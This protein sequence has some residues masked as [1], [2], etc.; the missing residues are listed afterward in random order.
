MITRR[1]IIIAA[2]VVAAIATPFVALAAQQLLPACA[3]DYGRC[4]IN[5]IVQTFVNF[6]RLLL[7][8]VGS[9]VL[10]FFIYGGFVWL[11]SGGSSE[12]IKK[13]KDVVVNS[14][15]GLIIVFGAFTIVQFISDSLGVENF[16]RVGQPCINGEQAG[17][18]VADPASPRS[19]L[20]CITSCAE[21]PLPAA[22]YSCRD[23]AD[24]TNCI[25]GL[26]PGSANNQ[27]CQA[28]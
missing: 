14:I 24:G 12:K 10:V 27:C 19:P 6:M 13:G 1:N 20:L 25:P 22:G 9:A 8:F 3:L 23:E 16:T 11:T 17:V 21:A 15:I 5:D 4:H 2:G 28:P 18:Y 26:C 7:G